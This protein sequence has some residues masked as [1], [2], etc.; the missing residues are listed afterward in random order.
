MMMMM[1]ITTTIVITWNVDGGDDQFVVVVVVSH[2]FLNKKKWSRAPVHNRHVEK[3]KRK[4]STAVFS[5]LVYFWFRIRTWAFRLRHYCCCCKKKCS[6]YHTNYAC[7]RFLLCV[8]HF[9]V[10]VSLAF[11]SF[12]IERV[13]VCIVRA[14]VQS[15]TIQNKNFVW[16]CDGGNV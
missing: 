15:S 1:I 4:F 3:K 16:K 11:V 5:G 7:M 6:C 12:E 9:F 14:H 8:T 10:V 2:R 13:L